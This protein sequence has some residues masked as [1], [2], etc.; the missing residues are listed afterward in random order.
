MMY[1]TD[2]EGTF[3]WSEAGIVRALRD[4]AAALAVDGWTSLDAAVS[5]IAER[6]AGLNPDRYGCNGWPQVLNESRAFDLRYRD[7][8]GRRAPWFRPRPHLRSES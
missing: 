6:E 5:W 4:A 3:D 2:Q 8:D 7:T 1:W